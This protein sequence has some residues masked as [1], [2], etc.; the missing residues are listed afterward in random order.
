MDETLCVTARIGSVCMLVVAM[1]QSHTCQA[2]HQ[3]P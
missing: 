1:Q 2:K 3:M